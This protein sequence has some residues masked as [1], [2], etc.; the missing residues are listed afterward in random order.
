MTT[1][2]PQITIAMPVFNAGRTV[3]AALRSILLQG[4][5]DWELLVM[6][7]GSSDHTADEVARFKDARIRFVAGDGNC[8]LAVRLNQAISMARGALFARMDADDV[9][10]PSRLGAQVEFLRQHPE[11]DLVG[12]GA[13][14]FDDGGRITGRFDV[15][16]THEAICRDPWRGFTLPHPTWMGRRE[17]FERYRYAEDYRKTQDQD[18]LLRAFDSSRFACIEEVLLGYRQDRR[19][20]AKLVRGRGYFIRSIVR[21]AWRRRAW[22]GAA[23]GV[24]GQVMKGAIDLVT[25]PLRLDRLIRGEAAAT[26]TEAQ[27][28]QWHQVWTTSN[29]KNVSEST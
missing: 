7:D 24:A 19:T 5:R 13:V 21:E 26:V 8:G 22:A 29:S 17:W 10:Y 1:A 2:A 12:C 28:E 11:C 20:V 9:A 18:L 14:I 3:A 16:A 25:V 15:H 23:R 27:R 6:D 4:C